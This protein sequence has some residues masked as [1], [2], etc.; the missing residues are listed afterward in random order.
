[1]P[2]WLDWLEDEPVTVAAPRFVRT[3]ES[4]AL[5]KKENAV[6]G[7]IQVHEMPELVPILI[8]VGAINAVGTDYQPGTLIEVASGGRRRVQESYD[9]VKALIEESP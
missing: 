9:Q 6:Q 3:I 5:P 2:G 1:M 4:I 7:F 8:R